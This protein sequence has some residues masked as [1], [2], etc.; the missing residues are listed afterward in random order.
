[1]ARELLSEEQLREALHTLPGWE[2]RDGKLH[3]DL[4]F[5]DF[6]AAFAFM[7]G[8]ALHAQSLDHHPDWTNVYN[9]VAISLHTHDRG[10]ITG[11]DLELARRMSALAAGQG[12]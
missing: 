2:V 8:A 4:Q 1:M 12:R 6:V 7:A 3:R 5:D 11:L 10:G 9:R